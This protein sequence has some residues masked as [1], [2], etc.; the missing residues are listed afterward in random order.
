MITGHGNVILRLL[1]LSRYPTKALTLLVFLSALQQFHIKTASM[2]RYKCSRAVLFT[3]PV[4]SEDKT[5][6]EAEWKNYQMLKTLGVC[7]YVMSIRKERDI[8]D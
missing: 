8:F 2:H 4:L 3:G 6:S 1:L 5:G 7:L